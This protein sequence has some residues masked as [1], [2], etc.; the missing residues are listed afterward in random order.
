VLRGRSEPGLLAPARVAFREGEE[1]RVLDGP[2]EA[3]GYVWWQV[4]G[5]GGTGWS[6]EQS[7]DGVVW[8]V[9]LA[10]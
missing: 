10:E 3:D 5:P 7:P 1:L 9:P 4:E 8:L 2:I 6:A